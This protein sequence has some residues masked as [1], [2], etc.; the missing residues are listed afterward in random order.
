MNRRLSLGLML[1]LVLAMLA[2]LSQ[3]ASYKTTTE[4]LSLTVR[5][6][7]I[8]KI[9]TVSRVIDGMIAQH[10]RRLEQLTKLLAGE[11]ELPQALMQSEPQRRASIAEFLDRGLDIFKVD[12]LEVTDDREIMVYRAHAPE[13]HGDRATEW[14][15]AE[16]LAG[17]GMLVSSNSP[18]GILIRAVEPLRSGDRVTGTLSAGIRLNEAFFQ[19]LSREVSAELALLSRSGKTLAMSR[20]LEGKIDSQAVTEAFHQK[21]PIYRED[22]AAR[23]T[24]VYLPVLIVDE[25]YV[26]VAQIN[27]GSAYQMLEQS[28]RHSAGYA[29][30]I[31]VGCVVLGILALRYALAPLRRLRARAERTA[32]ELTGESIKAGAGDEVSSVVHVLDT[33]TERLI[34]RNRDLAQA[35]E[36]ADLANESKTQ[37]LS[38][39]SHEIRT[40]L[41]GVLGMAELLQHTTLDPTQSRYVEAIASAGR[42]LH[43]LLSD[44]LDLAKIESGKIVLEQIDFDT[45]TLVEDIAVVF[46]E[47]ASRRG[48]LLITESD[49]AADVRVAGDPTRLRQVLSNLLGNA[50]KF[51]ERGTVTLCRRRIDPPPGDSRI[52]LRFTVR[53]TGIGIAPDVLD[54]LFKP[55][56]QA[57]VSTTRQFGGSGLGLVISKHLVGLMGGS[58]HA[59]SAPGQGATFWIDLPFAQAASPSPTSQSVLPVPRHAAVRVLV[60][61]DNPVNQTV[62]EAMLARLGATPTM[63]SNGALAIESLQAG[64][65]DMVL[66]DCQMPVMNGY[67][68]TAQIRAS[69]SPGRRMPIIALTANALAED[70]ERCIAAGMDDYLAKPLSLASLSEML[71]RWAP[72]VAPADRGG[73]A[74]SPAVSEQSNATT[75]AS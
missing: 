33:L 50:V 43:G 35:K 37:F 17:T 64:K 70:R 14:G 38:N 10:A 60:A 28:A 29:A 4:L 36:A 19:A 32:V 62:I 65:F 21:I 25:A 54:L 16:A 55:F 59:D 63:V 44:V 39:M 69:E 27:S 75:Q 18:T 40:P 2:A 48:N 7:E 13:R 31:V 61:E 45:A 58:I 51:T 53:D 22:A 26:V 41:N 56:V 52:W 6:R 73:T 20:A 9:K 5:E 12:V 24:S 30:L 3:W 8:D 57:D 46:R 47:L 1:A 67:D 42:S 34:R 66:M 68:A 15:V 49:P 74:R 71:Q 72:A 23:L 11:D